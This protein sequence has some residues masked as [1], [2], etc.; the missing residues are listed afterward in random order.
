VILAYSLSISNLGAAALLGGLALGGRW[1]VVDESSWPPPSG[2]NIFKSSTISL[3]N[4]I[5]E[6]Q[7]L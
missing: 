5:I 7:I 1:E 3:K 6:L 2:L 4:K